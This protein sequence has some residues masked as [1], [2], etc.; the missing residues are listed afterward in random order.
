[1]LNAYQLAFIKAH[2]LF[3]QSLIIRGSGILALIISYYLYSQ[4]TDNVVAVTLALGTGYLLMFLLSSL[5]EKWILNLPKKTL[6]QVAIALLN[7]IRVLA[8]N[9]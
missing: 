8:A 6:H 7:A 9:E 2:G 4:I 1:M 5:V 3:T